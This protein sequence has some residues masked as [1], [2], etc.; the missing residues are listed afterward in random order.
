MSCNPNTPPCNCTNPT[1]VGIATLGTPNPDVGVCNDC[2]EG[3]ASYILS[4]H[5]GQIETECKNICIESITVYYN[6][7]LYATAPSAFSFISCD[8]PVPINVIAHDFTIGLPIPCTLAPRN[9]LCTE[10]TLARFT[11]FIL[12]LCPDFT[13]VTIPLVIDK[14]QFGTDGNGLTSTFILFT[15]TH[16]CIGTAVP[17]ILYEICYRNYSPAPDP[18]NTKEDYEVLKGLTVGTQAWEQ[19]LDITIMRKMRLIV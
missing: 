1:T 5:L 18:F 10:T 17:V 15:A 9:D 14:F 7:K 2:S 6:P 4:F 3:L 16:P 8:E 19:D 13:L 12:S 11:G